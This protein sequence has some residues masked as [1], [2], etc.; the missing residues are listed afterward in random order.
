[1]R[2]ARDSATFLDSFDAWI[3]AML[4]LERTRPGRDRLT[5]LVTYMFRVISPLHLEPLRAKLRTLGS[6]TEELAM[7]IAEQLRKEGIQEGLKKGRLATLRSLLLFKFH[8]LGA[9]HE[10]RLKA[11]TPEAIDRYLQRLLTAD[12]LAAVFDD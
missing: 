3:P 6:R 9:K 4:E 1:L 10:A 8:T 5:T 11:A 2:D 7:T 12:S